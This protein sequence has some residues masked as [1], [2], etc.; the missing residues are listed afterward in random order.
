MTADDKI[1]ERVRKLLRLATSDNVHEAANAAASAQALIDRYRI[2]A[3]TRGELHDNPFADDAIVETIDEPLDA[4][5][6]LRKW[7]IFLATALAPVQDC[8]VYVLD[9][10]GPDKIRRLIAVGRPTDVALL[11]ELYRYTVTAIECLTR[12]HGHDRDDAWREGFRVGA[13][14]T[15]VERLAQA[16]HDAL[17]DA[18]ALV[19]RDTVP[20]DASGRHAGE[21]TA[22]LARVGHRLARRLA[23]VDA[24]MQRKP[25]MRSGKALRV[26]ADGYALGQIAGNDIDLPSR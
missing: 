18:D 3:V 2:D 24:F 7:K 21:S 4:S 10:T 26:H 25:G 13:A 19:S 12:A 5:K 1:L 14:N 17:A 9:P 22:A 23:D 15:I 20:E 6:R 8:R 16:R 11:A